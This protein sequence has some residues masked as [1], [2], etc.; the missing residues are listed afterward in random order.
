MTTFVSYM[1]NFFIVTAVK[2]SHQVLSLLEKMYQHVVLSSR[3][4]K[5]SAVTFLLNDVFQQVIAYIVKHHLSI[6]LVALMPWVEEVVAF[7]VWS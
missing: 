7:P 3:A 6:H 2:I 4:T 1:P 5:L